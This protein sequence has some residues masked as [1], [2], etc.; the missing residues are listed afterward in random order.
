MYLQKVMS[1]KLF[2]KFSFLLASWRSMTKKQD[3]DPGSGS[4]SGSISQRHGS[5]DPDP[6][7]NVMDPEH[8]FLLHLISINIDVSVFQIC[9][10]TF[11]ARWS[12]ASSPTWAA[13]P[14][15]TS[16]AISWP[17]SRR[18]KSPGTCPHW[19][20]SSSHITGHFLHR[21]C[22]YRFCGNLS[23]K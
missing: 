20:G 16:A 7:Q 8:C 6:H 22:G 12:P 21:K 2:K 19:S 14:T 18:R 4:E 3:P 1:R 17:A 9:L 13:W 11:W 15:W 10:G 5:V 23:E